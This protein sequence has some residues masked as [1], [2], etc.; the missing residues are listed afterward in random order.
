MQVKIAGSRGKQSTI[1]DRDDGLEKVHHSILIISACHLNIISDIINYYLG[2][3][4]LMVCK[5]FDPDKLKKLP[6]SFN[7]KGGS[8]T[9]G[10][11]SLIR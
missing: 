1:V 4:I 3:F 9:A 11:A 10:N 6:P 5:Q 2:N 8:V 7:K